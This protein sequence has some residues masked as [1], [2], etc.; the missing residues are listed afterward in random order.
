MN[1]FIINLRRRYKSI[2]KECELNGYISFYTARPTAAITLVNRGANLKAIQ[3]ALDH[4]NISMASRYIRRVEKIVM[5][6]NL[7]VL[8]PNI[9]LPASELT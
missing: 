7:V 5:G 6:K 9:L 1:V 3:T 8:Q 2:S 4:S